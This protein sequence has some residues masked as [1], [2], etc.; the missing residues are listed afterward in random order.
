MVLAL[1]LTPR[2][3]SCLWPCS[4][5]DSGYRW[6]MSIEEAKDLGLRA[7][8]SANA[9][10]PNRLSMGLWSISTLIESFVWSTWLRFADVCLTVYAGCRHATYRDAF[11]GGFI[12]VYLI[13]KDGWRRL[14]RVDSGLLNMDGT[15]V[16]EKSEQKQTIE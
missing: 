12:N 16:K 7:I 5:L 8:R 10:A 1:C 3:S 15:V 9:N 2:L 11:S 13:Q 4:I 6:D 14:T